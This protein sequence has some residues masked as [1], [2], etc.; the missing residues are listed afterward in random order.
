MPANV[1]VV[2]AFARLAILPALRTL[3][4][5]D[6]RTNPSGFTAV[7][8]APILRARCTENL[9][10]LS[11]DVAMAELTPVLQLAEWT[12][13]IRLTLRRPPGLSLVF[14]RDHQGELGR[15]AIELES[16]VVDD[17][18]DDLATGLAALPADQ[19]SHVAVTTGRSRTVVDFESAE[20][21]TWGILRA[22]L[23]HQQRWK[24]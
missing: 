2:D 6:G 14:T 22:A 5:R 17:R 7:E 11:C 23:V 21:A 8:V 16:G 10:E 9:C 1:A 4:L 3:S 15:L 19:L 24:H 18:L 12:S 20:A 13:V